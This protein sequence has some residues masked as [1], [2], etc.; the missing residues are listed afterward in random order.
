M[1]CFNGAI[2]APLAI[3]FV[4]LFPWRKIVRQISPRASRAL[5]IENR[6]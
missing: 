1:Q 6:I 4:N 5:A 2:I 3:I